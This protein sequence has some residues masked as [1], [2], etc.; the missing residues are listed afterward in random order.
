MRFVSGCAACFVFLS[1]RT[2]TGWI[3]RPTGKGA[4]T[5]FYYDLGNHGK[6]GHRFVRHR[7]D[8]LSANQ[9]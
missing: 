1:N 4:T 9:L 2:L 8:Q 5:F 7:V 6:E 3:L